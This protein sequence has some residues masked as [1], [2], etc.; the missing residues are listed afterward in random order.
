MD[1]DFVSNNKKIHLI[2]NE[3]SENSNNI[4]LLYLILSGILLSFINIFPKI[5]L[6]YYKNNFNIYEFTVYRC[7]MALISSI[8]FN[9]KLIGENFI[10]I[11]KN[12][13]HKKWYL[14]KI[15]LNFFG[16]LFFL[17]SIYYIRCVTSRTI[18]ISFPLILYIINFIKNGKL[19]FNKLF[20]FMIFSFLCGNILVIS[21]ETI[22]SNNFYIGFFFAF[23]SLLSYSF[24]K[25]LKLRFSSFQ[26]INIYFRIYYNNLITFIYSL[27]ILLFQKF[28]LKKHNFSFKILYI[29]ICSLNGFFL[30]LTHYFMLIPLSNKVF[31]F[32]FN[33]FDTFQIYYIYIF[34]A[35]FTNDNVTFIDFVGG[36]I[37]IVYLIYNSFL[38]RY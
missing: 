32:Q 30:V 36:G 31:M 6:T 29:I 19:N 27:I 37:I 5:L 7:G 4:N 14:L 26:N 24:I 28:I 11:F 13:P 9:K 3:I 15:N 2:K 38:N 10:E 34:C 8:I 18:L 33:F 12:L 22:F 23:I 25:E 35:L 16:Y 20:F 17:Y 1:E 21:N